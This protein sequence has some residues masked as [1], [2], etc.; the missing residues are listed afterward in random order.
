MLNIITYNRNS[1]ILAFTLML[2]VPI[3]SCKK[4]DNKEE[5]KNST[6]TQFNTE[7]TYGTFTD[8]RDGKSYKTIKIGD[9]TWFAENLAYEIQGNEENSVDGWQ[10]S[11]YTGGNQD[12]WTYYKGDKNKYGKWGILYQY[13][14]AKMA[15]PDGWHIPTANEWNKLSEYLANNGY[16]FDGTK[17]GSTIKIG[18]SL[19]SSLGWKNSVISGNIGTKPGNNNSSGFSGIPAV[20]YDQDRSGSDDDENILATW[21][22]NSSTLL[23]IQVRYLY[24]GSSSLKS[25]I[26]HYGGGYSVRCIKTAK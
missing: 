26:R 8:P 16:N 23:N 14:A 11:S 1:V 9:Q 7:L 17:G 22:T 21:W 2:L 5:N 13:K 18:K 20:S 4:L 6:G 15:C 12:R 24:Y 19:A 25:D 10:N 3:T